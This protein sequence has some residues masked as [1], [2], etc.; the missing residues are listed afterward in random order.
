MFKQGEK[1]VVESRI[2]PL[3]VKIPFKTDI[4]DSGVGK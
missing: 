1:R 3:D 4:E 2:T